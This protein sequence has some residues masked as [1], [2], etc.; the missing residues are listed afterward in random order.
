MNAENNA[1]PVFSVQE[2]QHE[3]QQEEIGLSEIKS[4]VKNLGVI[5][6]R[7]VKRG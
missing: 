3:L 7:F 6:H 4:I 2:R 5:S 1:A